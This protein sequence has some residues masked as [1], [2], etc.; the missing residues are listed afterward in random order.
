M[1]HYPA[2]ADVPDWLIAVEPGEPG[3]VFE[4][5]KFM[6]PAIV[7]DLPDRYLVF[8]PD[9]QQPPPTLHII[10]GANRVY[11]AAKPVH[12]VQ[13]TAGFWTLDVNAWVPVQQTQEPTTLQLR[14]LSEWTPQNAAVQLQARRDAQL[15]RLDQT[16]RE[17]DAQQ[18]RPGLWRRLWEALKAS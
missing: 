12:L 10:G 8:S 18:A 16:I 14:P 13:G 5:L 6:G 9:L 11:A 4:S 3:A 15:E 2:G 7:V 1:T 17:F